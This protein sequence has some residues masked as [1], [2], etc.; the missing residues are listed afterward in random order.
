MLP[1]KEWVYI[2]EAHI[3]HYLIVK[4]NTFLIC[5]NGHVHS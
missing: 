1:I 2:C 3:K 5:N 4:Q